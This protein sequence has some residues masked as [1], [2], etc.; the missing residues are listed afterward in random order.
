MLILARKPQE[1]VYIEVEGREIKVLVLATGT[2]QCRLGFEA[3]KD[4]VIVRD[5]VENKAIRRVAPT[6]R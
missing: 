3:P 4:V 6:R 5:E 2:G 1:S